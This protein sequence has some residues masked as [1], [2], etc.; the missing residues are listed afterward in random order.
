MPIDFLAGLSD[1]M[2]EKEIRYAF[3]LAMNGSVFP[4]YLPAWIRRRIEKG[5]PKK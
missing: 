3:K 5:A 4:K 1:E 2:T